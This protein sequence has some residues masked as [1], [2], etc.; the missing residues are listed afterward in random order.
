M[1]VSRRPSGKWSYEFQYQGKRHGRYD[2]QNKREAAAAEAVHR[3]ELLRSRT[4]ITFLTAATRRLEDLEAYRSPA[5]FRDNRAM[6]KR[7]M[8][9]AQFPVN[10][11]TPDMLK[12]YLKELARELGP[13][14]ANRHLIALKAC[15]GQAVAEG[16][17]LRNPA[18]G[19][20]K[21]PV[22]RRAKFVPSRQQINV[23]L[24][25]AQPLDRAYLTVIWQLGARVREINRLAW[26][27]VNLER[28]LVRLHTKK[29]RGGDLTPR[30]V[31]TSDLAVSA[32][33]LAWRRR[34]PGSPWVFTNPAMAAR[35]PDNS[36]TWAYDYRDKFFA[37]LCR[38]AGV[39]AMGYHALRHARASEL[40]LERLPLTRIRDFLGHEDI[41]TTSRYLHSLGIDYDAGNW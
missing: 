19:L 33:S 13:N 17:L 9:W 15:L 22:A 30:L 25:L 3:A 24:L 39:P 40:A 34:H 37:R 31:E 11:L 12:D 23:V 14:N 27:D 28:R 7:F 8:S 20:P 38:L 2:F 21:F 36:Q 4:S 16:F 1:T 18:A 35:H 32:L 5:H 6:L 29:K 41:T 10:A 26:E